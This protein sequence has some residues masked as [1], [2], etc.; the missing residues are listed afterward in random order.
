MW[1]HTKDYIPWNIRE[2]DTREQREIRLYLENQGSQ[3]GKNCY[4]SPKANLCDVTLKTGDDCEFCADVLIRHADVKMG[5]RCSI[6]P[7]AY[8]QGRITMGD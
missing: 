2:R 4:I 7:M 3:I 1:E 5:M 8:V 6:N